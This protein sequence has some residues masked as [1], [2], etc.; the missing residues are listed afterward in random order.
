MHIF[1]MSQ[2]TFAFRTNASLALLK[3]ISTLLNALIVP[4]CIIVIL[5]ILNKTCLQQRT[6]T[7]KVIDVCAIAGV[8]YN[9]AA[10]TIF[11]SVTCGDAL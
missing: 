7:L 4:K 1:F 11:L 3:I 8:R 9:R 10:K 6:V 5:V 2:S